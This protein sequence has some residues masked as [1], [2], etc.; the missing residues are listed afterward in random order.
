MRLQSKL[1]IRNSRKAKAIK[2]GIG[3][4]SAAARP[5]APRFRIFVLEQANE[6]QWNKGSLYNAGFDHIHSQ[7]KVRLRLWGSLTLTLSCQLGC[8]LF[9][10][11]Y[12]LRFCG[13]AFCLLPSGSNLC[14][15]AATW[16]CIAAVRLAGVFRIPRC[17]LHTTIEIRTQSH[18]HCCG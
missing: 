1:L 15:P 3:G 10:E 5:L 16:S 2:Y 13:T 7:T 12:N 4:G 17:G 18:H 6:K 9:V 11:K 14:V 8:I